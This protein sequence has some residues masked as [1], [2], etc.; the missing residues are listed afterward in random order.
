MYSFETIVATPTV[1]NSTDFRKTEVTWKLTGNQFCSIERK[2]ANNLPPK[3]F[4][5]RHI[6][7]S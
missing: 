6:P 5:Q 2:G 7:L 4:P 1:T 3:R